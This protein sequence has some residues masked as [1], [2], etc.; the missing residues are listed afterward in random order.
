V[1]L[2]WNFRGEGGVQLSSF[3]FLLLYRLHSASTLS[4]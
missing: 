3:Y 2:L 4:S 1:E